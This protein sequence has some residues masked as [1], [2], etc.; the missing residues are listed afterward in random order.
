MQTFCPGNFV[1]SEGSEC[2][3]SNAIFEVA[4]VSRK[5]VTTLPMFQANH[6]YY[7]IQNERFDVINS[8]LLPSLKSCEKL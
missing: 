2:D 4:N 5:I 6:K 1:K 8:W 7:T 3:V